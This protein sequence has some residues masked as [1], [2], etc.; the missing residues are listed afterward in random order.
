MRGQLYKGQKHVT[1]KLHPTQLVAAQMLPARS[2]LDQHDT[3]TASLPSDKDGQNSPAK[4][5]QSMVGIITLPLCGHPLQGTIPWWGS[6]HF[7]LL[8]CI[9]AFVGSENKGMSKR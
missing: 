1:S 8:P 2:W 7:H 3:Q 9:V 5:I 4:S 6:L